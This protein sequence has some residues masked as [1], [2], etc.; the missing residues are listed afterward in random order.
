MTDSL[1]HVYND[2]SKHIEERIVYRTDTLRLAAK[3]AD[4]TRHSAHHAIQNVQHYVEAV[5]DSGT[6]P[7]S[8]PTS[9]VLPAI[10]TCTSALVADSIEVKVLDAQIHD[11]TADRDVWKSR[12]IMDEKAAKPS[13]FGFKSGAVAGFLAAVAV[14]VILR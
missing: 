8:L 4:S 14:K 5:S 9:L 3:L 1:R 11:L 13:R 6:T 10:Q 12:A 7:D 2:S